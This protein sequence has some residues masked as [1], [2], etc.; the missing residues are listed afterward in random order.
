MYVSMLKQLISKEQFCL[1]FHIFFSKTHPSPIYSKL[2][3]ACKLE[4]TT[5]EYILELLFSLK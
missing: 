1:G 4:T 3:R 5:S 2:T